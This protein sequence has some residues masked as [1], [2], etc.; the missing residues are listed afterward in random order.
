MR[1]Q[2][3]G[4]LLPCLAALV[5]GCTFARV[6]TNTENFHEKV[7]QVV[8]GTTTTEELREI[9]G[10]DPNATVELF[11]G[12][13][14]MLVY[15]FGDSKT[16]ALNLLILNISRTNVGADSAY[17]ITNKEGIVLQ[18]FV[19]DYSRDLSWDWWAFGG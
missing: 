8:L 5:A 11:G 4:L 12:Q 18:M 10:S 19:S 1:I 7:K 3:L 6:R 14:K 13:A 16:M 15:A 2:R 9:L 17:F